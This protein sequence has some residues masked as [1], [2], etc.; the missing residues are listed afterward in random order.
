MIK[1]PKTD[2]FVIRYDHS[3]NHEKHNHVSKNN[4]NNHYFWC[5]KICCRHDKYDILTMTMLQMMNGILISNPVSKQYCCKLKYV[6]YACVYCLKNSNVVFIFL[7]NHKLQHNFLFDSAPVM[8]VYIIHPH[9]RWLY[10]KI[11]HFHWIWCLSH[12]DISYINTYTC[13]LNPTFIRRLLLTS[14]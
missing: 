13:N 10:R 9:G 4:D 2:Y 1:Q 3:Y 5:R 6:H 14:K 12:K 8:G 7:R 11:L